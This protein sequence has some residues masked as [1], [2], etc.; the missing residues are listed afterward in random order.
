M[1]SC[2]DI[3]HCFK[4]C[5]YLEEKKSLNPGCLAIL[6][7]GLTF[8]T[9]NANSIAQEARVLKVDFTH[10]CQ[11]SLYKTEKSL[12][13]NGTSRRN[14][15]PSSEKPPG[16]TTSKTHTDARKIMKLYYLEPDYVISTFEFIISSFRFVSNQSEYLRMISLESRVE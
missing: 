3:I 16:K 10:T 9:G 6:D 2:W 13:W 14:G 8:H 4:N 5:S 1:G 15:P 7:S 11:R 12:G